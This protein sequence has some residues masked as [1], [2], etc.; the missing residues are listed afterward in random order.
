MDEA[1]SIGAIGPS[2]RGIV[3]L[4]NCNPKD[5]DVMMGT[6]TKSFGSC[7]GYIAGS[8]KLIDCL[9][10]TS[11]A[12]I[13]GASM[14]APVCMQALASLEVIMGRDGTN[15]GL[16]RIRQLAWNTRYFRYHLHKMGFIIYG[17]RDSPVVPLMLFQPA[18]IAAFSR[19]LLKRHIAA[20]VVGFPATTVVESRARF[21]LS[22]A[23]TKEMLDATLAAIDQVGN[24]LKLKYSYF[25]PCVMRELANQPTHLNFDKQQL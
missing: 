3:E 6:F 1:H 25:P 15:D 18:K 13:Y 22:A 8:R 14:S 23:H 17:N 2:G 24:L 12:A 21:C 19:E 9:R 20:V 10:S 4:F 11:Q 16:R 7:G 5:V